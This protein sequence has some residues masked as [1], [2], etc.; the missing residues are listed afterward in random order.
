MDEKFKNEQINKQEIESLKDIDSS[1]VPSRFG[2]QFGELSADAKFRR[3]AQWAS[4]AGTGM[5]SLFFFFFLVWHVLNPGP[6]DGWLVS[7]INEQYAATVGV[8]LSAITAFCIVT[9]LNVISKGDIEFSFLGLSFKGA[10]GPVILWVICFLTV[11]FGF[12][13][14]WENT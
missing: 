10:S 2:K 1:A 9:L 5:A 4:V 11:V 8:P 13:M 6:A 14:L 7:I 12:S 3:L